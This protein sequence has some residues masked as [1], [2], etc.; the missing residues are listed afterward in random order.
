MI[1]D[2]ENLKAS[3]NA[4]S[5]YSE[6]GWV[7]EVIGLVIESKGPRAKIGDLCYI[8]SAG[9][10]SDPLP[11][12][13]VGFKAGKLLLMPI[14]DMTA[15]GPGSRV[16]NTNAGF[17]VPVGEGLLGRVVDGLG[18]PMDQ[19]GPIRTTQTWPVT[20][21][22]PAALGRRRITEPLALGVRCLD[23]FTTLG[24]GQRVGIFA[25]SGVGKSTMLGMISRNTEADLNVIA[26]VGERGREVREFI[27]ESLG[28][29]G[30]KRSVVVVATSEQPALM[31]IKAALVATTI[32]EY[33][34]GQGKSVLLM[35]DSLTR[36]AMALREVGLSIGEPPTSRGYTPSMFAFLPKLLE[37]SGTDEHGSITGLYTVLVEGDDFNEPVSDT[38]RGLL[39]GHIV[40]SRDLAYQNHFP[41]MD[42]LGSISRLMVQVAS[43]EH[44]QA[45]GRIRDLMAI[46]K[47]SEDI[48]TIGAYARGSNSKLDQAIG[49]K[50]AI[51]SFLRQDVGEEIS[52]S[53]TV[54]KLLEIAGKIK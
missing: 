4:V 41:A 45:A 28:E 35:L 14:G 21:E 33:F 11:A 54:N 30:L 12:E 53:E 22:A 46:Y 31:K 52:F 39:D 44:N 48:I 26:L 1:V 5:P 32:A 18:R 17:S 16:V 40:L 20:A 19:K 42:V 47:R 37:R 2:L 25:G 8:Y 6:I 23:G 9:N 49:F 10:H 51:D 7:D 50:D 43:P 38:V 29:E 36:V 3:I 27:E 34:R 15:L 13:V 24:K